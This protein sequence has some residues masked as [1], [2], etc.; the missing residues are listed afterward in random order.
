MLSGTVAFNCLMGVQWPATSQEVS[1]AEALLKELALG[2]V[3]N[4]MPARME[5][6]VGETGWRLSH[7]EQSRIFVARVL[8]RK[9]DVVLLDES[10]GA[11]DPDTFL[12]CLR[13]IERHAR[14]VILV[15][16]R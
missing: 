11:L 10:F 12:L 2:P 1:D 4:A 5:Q 13:V 9:P 6:A 15:A 16:H 3:L 7:G 14:S 8:L